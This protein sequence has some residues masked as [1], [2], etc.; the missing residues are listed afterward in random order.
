MNNL[1]I[2]LNSHKISGIFV[3]L[4]RLDYMYKWSCVCIWVNRLVQKC[5]HNCKQCVLIKYIQLTITNEI[6]NKTRSLFK[7]KWVG[8]FEWKQGR[9]VSGN[10]SILA[11]NLIWKNTRSNKSCATLFYLLD[12][13]IHISE[14]LWFVPRKVHRHVTETCL[15]LLHHWKRY[16]IWSLLYKNNHK[17]ILKC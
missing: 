9:L 17:V 1:H 8:P 6:D 2:L 13:I 5:P 10:L 3:R 11:W 16:L 14:K 15:S 12:D 7:W 4:S